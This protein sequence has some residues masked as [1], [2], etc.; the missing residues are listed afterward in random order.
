M[1]PMG[2]R[3]RASR[4]TVVMAPPETRAAQVGGPR[5]TARPRTRRSRQ[6]WLQFGSGTI[7]GSVVASLAGD[8]GLLPVFCHRRPPV[9]ARRFW[10]ASFGSV[11]QSLLVNL[12]PLPLA[13]LPSGRSSLSAISRSSAGSKVLAFGKTSVNSAQVAEKAEDA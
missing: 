6:R 4:P 10:P 11:G 7:T 9:E 2:L 13:R 8:F 5:G 3:E 12:M 1:P